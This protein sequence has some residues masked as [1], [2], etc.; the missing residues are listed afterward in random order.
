M[1]FFSTPITALLLLSLSINSCAEKNSSEKSKIE[2]TSIPITEIINADLSKYSQA[3]FAEGCFWCTEAVFES[4]KGVQEAVSGYAGGTTKNPTYEE[5][6]AE[7]TGHAEGVTVYYDSAVVDFPTLVKVFFASQDPT[8]VNGQG[9]DHGSSYR[10]IAFYR[11]AIEKKIIEDYI[12]QL[13]ASGKFSAPIA[14]EVTP[15][16]V[17]WK[18]EDYHQNYI[19]HHP[20]DNPYVTNESIPRIKR[21]QKQFPELIKP[22][23]SLIKK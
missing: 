5:V 3:T 10:S 23:K 17:F 18:A 12:A 7:G 4:V 6:C 8:Q 11:N 19:Q 13:N 1:K 2:E 22:E 9:P 20:N 16:T 14:A 21:F 15:F